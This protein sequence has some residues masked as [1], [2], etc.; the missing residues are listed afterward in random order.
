MRPLLSMRDALRDPEVFAEVLEGESWSGWRTLLIAIMGEG[1]TEDERI[2]FE[3]LT[4]RPR[5]PL[6]RIE[7][8]FLVIG[9]RSGKTRAAAVLAAYFGGSLRL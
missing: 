2:V 6:Q 5:E 7:E 1:L 8:A 3:F 9:R 4:G